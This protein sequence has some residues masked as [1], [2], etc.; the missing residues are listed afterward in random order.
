MKTMNAAL[1]ALLC[2]TAAVPGA[3]AV[4]VVTT[5]PDLAALAREVG[6]DRVAVESL[7]SGVQNAHH[8][9]PKP[10]HV[11]KVMK[12]DL[13]VQTGLELEAAWADPVLAAA[14]N[15]RV[16][17]GQPGFLDASEAVAPL[18]VPTEVTRAMGDVHPGGNPHYMQDP[19]R[20][21]QVAA[22]LA[23]RLSELDPGGAPDYAARLKDFQARLAERLKVWTAR[24]APF[25]GAKAVTYH[26]DWVYF[27]D[28]FGLVPFGEIEPKPGIPPTA[29]HTADLIARMKA[30]GVRLVLTVPWYEE[31]TPQA[32]AQATGARVAKAALL[33]GAFPGTDGYFG[34][35][36]YNVEAVAK[37]LE[38]R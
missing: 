38:A 27:S 25:K 6:G 36:D 33:P 7:A 26:R 19:V 14:R 31:R 24:L 16:R 22:L 23:K 8:I 30:E 10:S 12:A 21:G 15:R 11:V 37:A 5:T 13:F 35:M 29:Q 32:V 17:P 28:R 9:D 1:T 20:A 34:W 18:E 3:A 2:V 4:K